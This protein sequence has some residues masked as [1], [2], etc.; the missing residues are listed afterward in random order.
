MNVVRRFRRASSLAIWEFCLHFEKS[1]RT[2]EIEW[3]VFRDMVLG[4]SPENKTYLEYKYFK[5]KVVK[6]AVAE[7]NLTSDHTIGLVESKI[8][9]RIST[10]SFRIGRKLG[11]CETPRV[12]EWIQPGETLGLFDDRGSTST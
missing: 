7:I 10:I 4:E 8:G 3:E 5:S 1:G 2:A 12:V 11:A 9:K 6:P